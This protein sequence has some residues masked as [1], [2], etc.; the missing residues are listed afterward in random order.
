MLCFAILAHGHKDFLK[1]Q[2]ENIRHFNPGCRIVLYNGGTDEKLGEGLDVDICPYSRPLQLNVGQGVGRCLFDVMKW[3]D[4]IQLPYQFLVYADS[5]LVFVNR[6]FE[7]YLNATM[8]NYDFMA[9][10]V[11]KY[12]PFHASSEW[13]LVTDMMS[14]WSQWQPFFQT[15]YFYGTFNPGQ[16]FRRDIVSKVL[17]LI[18]VPLL[19]RLLQQTH[20]FALEETLY[21]TLVVRAGGNVRSYLEPQR[22]YDSW[23]DRLS[24][25]QVQEAART[26]GVYF[27]HPVVRDVHDSAASW[28]AEVMKANAG[29]TPAEGGAVAVQPPHS[30][31][32]PEMEPILRQ[33]PS[34]LQQLPTVLERLQG[35]FAAEGSEFVTQLYRQFL[36]RDPDDEGLQFQLR[37]L[38]ETSKGAVLQ[39]FVTSEEFRSLVT[40][41]PGDF[42]P[43]TEDGTVATRLNFWFHTSDEVFVSGLYWEVLARDPDAAGL[44]THLNMLLSNPSRHEVL[45][46]ILFSQEAF[47]RI[48]VN[49]DGQAA[50]AAKPPFKDASTVPPTEILRTV[51]SLLKRDG[52]AFVASLYRAV[53]G[54]NPRRRTLRKYLRKMRSGAMKW[55]VLQELLQTRPSVAR[56]RR[57]R[58]LKRRRTGK[59]VRLLNQIAMYD[60]EEFIRATYHQVLG[61]EPDP[62]GFALHLQ[63]LQQG[64]AKREIIYAV[65][66]SQ[67]AQNSLSSL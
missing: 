51:N 50:V 61:R 3:L 4:E 5:D 34:D 39:S 64:T 14:E 22:M 54:L 27:V 9:Q 44:Q 24:L 57:T 53:Y 29:D 62:S 2:I 32:N 52:A 58:T 15:D 67:E 37:L 20:V 63:M 35:A 43:G 65:L 49:S 25:E 6:G 21:V 66:F 8:E 18:D 55:Q 33:L 26:P 38:S 19:E 56:N 45:Q 1:L 46:S 48:G 11:E 10:H 59:L 13:P 28:I 47:S 30:E 31:Q 42:L 36:N 23:P 60:G 7:D 16:V 17:S 40:A 41:P 12:D